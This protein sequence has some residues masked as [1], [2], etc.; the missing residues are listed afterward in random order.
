M[1]FVMMVL[2]CKEVWSMTSHVRL[3]TTQDILF[4]MCCQFVI[5]NTFWTGKIVNVV[6]FHIISTWSSSWASW[7]DPH[8]RDDV[9]TPE[10]FHS[11]L[12]QLYWCDVMTSWT[13]VG[14]SFIL[15]LIE[16]FWLFFFLA[17]FIQFLFTSSSCSFLIIMKVQLLLRLSFTSVV[18]RL[19]TCRMIKKTWWL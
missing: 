15:A 13:L 1:Y 8:S 6:V 17:F 18:L 19:S 12:Q 14:W 9:I 7:T 2:F 4:L 11:T 5:K 3:R 16:V 10:L